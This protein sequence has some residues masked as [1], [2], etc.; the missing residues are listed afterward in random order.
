[1]QINKQNLAGMPHSQNNIIPLAEFIV[2]LDD[3]LPFINKNT[4][5]ANKR[6]ELQS[7]LI[8]E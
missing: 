8:Y 1:M 7:F 4:K 2:I 3:E 5:E 6:T